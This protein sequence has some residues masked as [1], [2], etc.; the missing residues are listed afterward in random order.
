[1]PRRS[2]T[3]QDGSRPATAAWCVTSIS[4]DRGQAVQE[5]RTRLAQYL[6]LPAF[7]AVLA[8]SRWESVIGDIQVVAVA[9]G[10]A[11]AGRLIPE[12][13]LDHLS[14]TGTPEEAAG[15]LADLVQRLAA[16]GVDEIALQIARMSGPPEAAL[17]DV[18]QI[19]A[20]ASSIAS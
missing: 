18:E 8:G 13:L 10:W 16:A 4:E 12:D 15:R 3:R 20:V 9:S 5:A 11:A 14:V 6:S 19:V 17:D 2:I 7:A 1:M